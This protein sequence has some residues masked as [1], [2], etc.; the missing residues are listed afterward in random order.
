M[1]Y[2]GNRLKFGFSYV[3]WI[4]QYAANFFRPDEGGVYSTNVFAENQCLVNNSCFFRAINRH[5]C[6]NVLGGSSLLI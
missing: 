3:S 5:F 2:F 6:Q 1:T 4:C